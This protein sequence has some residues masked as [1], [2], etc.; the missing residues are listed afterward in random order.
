MESSNRK[1]MTRL[2]ETKKVTLMTFAGKYRF[3]TG[4][5]CVLSGISSVIALA[6]Y[7]C[8][9]N[10]VKEVVLTW[11]TGLDGR[12]LVHWGWLAVASSLISML[13]YYGALMCTHLSAFRTARNMKTAALHHLTR[14][15]IGYFKQEG[16]G[17][18][19][20]IIDDGAGQTETYLAHQLPDLVGAIVTPVAVL[21]LL[22]VFDWRFGLISLVPMGVGVFFLSR[23]M[24]TG[25]AECMRQYQNAL[26][27]MNNEA[28]EYVRGIPV[29]KTFQQSIFSFK[30]F[31]DSILRY[32][33]W[34][35]N[36][37]I[38][39]RIPMCAYTVS[40]NGIFAIL[41]PAGI[42]LAGDISRGA[43]YTAAALDIIFYILFSPICVAM[44]DK[45]MWTSENTMAAKD[46]MNRV[47]KILKEEPLSEPPAPKK[48]KDYTIQFQDV[49][50]SY[51]KGGIAALDKVSLT[52]PQGATVA[53]VGASGSGKTTLVSLIPR[54]FDVNGGSITIGGA[55]V[56]EI[57]T[58]ELMKMVSFVFQDCHLFKDTLLNNIRAARPQAAEAEVRRAL[59]AA[60]C[61]DIIEKMPQGLHTVVGTKGVYLS[62]GEVQ[63]IA[64]ARAI[65]KDAPIVLLDEATAFADPDNEYLIQQGFEKLVEG[66]TVIMIA[67]RLST[68]C[69]ADR[70]FVMEKGHIAEEGS[71]NAL[72]AS[73]GLYARMWED[74]QRSV[75]WKVGGKV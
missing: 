72:L 49:T 20:R 15:P 34:A 1:I 11:N 64:L 52:V 16:S 54:F 63:R 29:V 48:P 71:H 41:I 12:S 7:L 18:L 10:V 56:R 36:Y 24:G 3:L 43:S 38:S 68:V 60:R 17:K 14:L 45:I 51:R 4:T 27:D 53:V 46:A 58:E 61:E 74:Y 5:G 25:M 62:G 21:V 65:L 9:W 59:E 26:E 42:L 13:F 30:S 50:F 47:L 66:K 67:H 70:I 33:D 32:R 55:D 28:V 22:L 31:H 69:R 39:L 75:E 35:V 23:M 37:T 6:P 44:M 2:P 8:M 73:G 40:I 57:G 19:R